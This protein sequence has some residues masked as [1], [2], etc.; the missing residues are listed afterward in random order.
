MVSNTR[1]LRYSN[2]DDVL[3]ITQYTR[4][5]L[6]I[7]LHRN[8]T[9]FILF[10]SAISSIEATHLLILP[11]FS[12]TYQCS[13]LEIG[14]INVAKSYFDF[15]SFSVNVIDLCSSWS[16]ITGWAKFTIVSLTNYLDKIEES[17]FALRITH[18]AI[19]MCYPIHN[20]SQI[21]LVFS[22]Y[23]FTLAVV[24]VWIEKACQ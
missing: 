22:S 5:M 10:H 2:D 11:I 18:Y 14:N 6:H 21:S 23:D 15:K 9:A 7:D 13:L 3:F 16:D 4:S 17:R 12:H 19:C 1:S 8:T 24:V 20:S